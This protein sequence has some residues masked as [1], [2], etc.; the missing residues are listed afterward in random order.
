M[1]ISLLHAVF[2]K[3]DEINGGSR[4]SNLVVSLHHYGNMWEALSGDPFLILKIFPGLILVDV[5]ALTKK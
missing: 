5:D 3:R 2:D 1:K 4:F